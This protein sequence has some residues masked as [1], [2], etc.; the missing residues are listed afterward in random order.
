MF[1]LHSVL[2]P[3]EKM[4]QARFLKNQLKN[5]L[6]DTPDDSVLEVGPFKYYV[7]MF[8]AFLGPPTNDSIN[9][10]VNQ[11]KLPFSD[12]PSGSTHPPLC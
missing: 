12:P 10:S 6:I 5:T 7:S 9:G 4:V 3:N 1:M 2:M 11:Q 8:L